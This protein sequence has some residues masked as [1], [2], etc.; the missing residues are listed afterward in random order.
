MFRFPLEKA[1][2]SEAMLNNGKRLN[3]KARNDNSASQTNKAEPS[4][5]LYLLPILEETLISHFSQNNR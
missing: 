1:Q 2:P 4:C 3:R 5:L